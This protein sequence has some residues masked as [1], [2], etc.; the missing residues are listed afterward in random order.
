MWNP[1]LTLLSKNTPQTV[2]CN[3]G[4]EGSVG[5]QTCFFSLL[6]L[7][8]PHLSHLGLSVCVLTCLDKSNL[9]KKPLL[10]TEHWY[11]GPLFSCTLR[12]CFFRPEALDKCNPHL[13][14]LKGFSSA[15]RS[16]CA[17]WLLTSSNSAKHW[18]HW[19]F[20]APWRPW[21]AKSII[22]QVKY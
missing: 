2:H 7:T 11:T 21:W 10:H 18:T 13:S 16:T 12:R 22:G 5:L 8:L 19:Y 6:D 3:S 4:S 17:L 20:L 14:H 15:C 9:S 1:H